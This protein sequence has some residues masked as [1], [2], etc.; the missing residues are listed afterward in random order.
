M[1]QVCA[2]IKEIEPTS[3]PLGYDSEAN[4]FI[5]MC[6]QYGSDYT[7]ATGEKYLFDN[8]QN[9]EFV[10]MFKG[11]YDKGYFTTKTI[12]KSYTSNLFKEQKS[13]MSIGSSAG[14]SNQT[15]TMTDGEAAFETGIV[16][17]PQVDTAHPKTISQGPSVCIFKKKN[18]QEV[19]ASWL[20][21]KFLTTD[22]AFQAQ[23]STVSG[24]VPVLKS[25]FE[26]PTYV[27]G[28]EQANGYATGITYTSAKVC[29]QLV[30][31]QAYYTSPAF[32][33]S[34]KARDQV[35][36]LMHKVFSD[37]RADVDKVIDEAFKN[38][39]AECKYFG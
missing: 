25:V 29:K 6:E 21:V 10:K 26:H 9:R 23:F 28:L 27:A 11:W 2:A 7:S 31:D 34:S 24:Y 16:Q 37:E 20:L 12:N 38:A 32:L 5:T 8:E 18:P 33:G 14:A 22:V 15:P 36:V 17:I 35:G 13:F 19:I 39:I 3:I 1:E 4:M 30:D